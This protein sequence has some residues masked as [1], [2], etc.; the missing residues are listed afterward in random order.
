MNTLYSIVTATKNNELTIKH[1][2]SSTL[3]LAE[4]YDTEL[5]VVEG[6]SADNTFKVVSDFISKNKLR[7]VTSKVLRDPGFS[8]SFA[9]HLGYKNSQGDVIVYLDGDTP[10]TITFRYYLEEE[11]KNNDLVSPLLECVRIDRATSVFNQFMKTV[12]YMQNNIVINSKIVDD[13]SVLPPARIFKREVLERMKGYPISS[14]FF[15]E[16]RITTSLAIKLGFRYRFSSRLKLLK[17]DEP[18]YNAYWKKHFRYGLGM[19]KDV[20]TLGKRVLRGYIIARRL[21]HLNTIV[22]LLS[23]VYAQKSYELIR[24]FK[25]SIDVALMKYLID[26][27]MLLGDVDGS[28]KIFR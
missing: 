7:Y 3:I 5:I 25:I 8:S 19:N 24:S 27:A 10:L 21:N 28:L 15:G 14:R 6:N 26:L 20:T 2:L 18:G 1:V 4:N 17:I 13:P 11:L 9:R 22:P 12:S 16:D 23:M